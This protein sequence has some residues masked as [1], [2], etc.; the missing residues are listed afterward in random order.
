MALH[1]ACNLEREGRPGQEGQE[2]PLEERE[3]CQQDC[4]S[5]QGGKYAQKTSYLTPKGMNQEEVQ[6]VWR[7]SSNKTQFGELGRW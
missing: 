2:K 5:E 3:H 4:G 7:K 6:Q 1:V